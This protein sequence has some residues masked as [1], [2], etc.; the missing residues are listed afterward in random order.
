[1]NP[2][3]A[4]AAA[5]IILQRIPARKITKI[6]EAAISIEVPKSGCLAIRTVGK[7]TK[8]NDT[9]KVRNVGGK[10]CFPIYLAIIRGTTNFKI[11]DG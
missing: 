11:S 7:Q 4:A 2:P 3:I 8:I 5:M 1:M 6:P 10:G 9:A